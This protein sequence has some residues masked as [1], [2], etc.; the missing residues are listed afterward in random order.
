MPAVRAKRQKDM[1]FHAALFVVAVAL[2]LLLEAAGPRWVQAI[3]RNVNFNSFANTSTMLAALLV[4]VVTHEAGHL[5][6]AW[7]CGFEILGGKLGPLRLE[8]LHGARKI[9]FSR[10][11]LFSC[12]I[13][14]VEAGYLR[15]RLSQINTNIQIDWLLRC[16][17][18]R[19]VQ[20][21]SV[22]YTI[23]T[24]LMAFLSCT[25]I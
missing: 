23:C 5:F 8:R 20:R 14:A 24:G 15:P 2:G 18:L 25:C 6:M 9:S 3:F 21:A 10:S 16:V 11:G 1:R 19:V 22:C 13:S 4:A 7:L 17:A 12:A